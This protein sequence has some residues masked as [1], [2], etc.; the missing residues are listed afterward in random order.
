MKGMPH[1]YE[2][3]TLIL[4]THVQKMGAAVC[5]RNAGVVEDST[6]LLIS[7]FHCLCE[8]GALC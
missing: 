5:P 4:R 8:L 7:Q 3:L 1:K 6:G 2:D